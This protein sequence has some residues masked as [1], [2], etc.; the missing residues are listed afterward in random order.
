MEDAEAVADIYLASRQVLAPYAPLA[1]TDG[2]VRQWI[3]DHLIP[4]GRVTVASIDDHIVA[5]LAVSVDEAGKWVDQLYV[6]PNAVNSGI[7][8]QLLQNAQATLGPP[9]RLY[10]FQDNVGARRFYE[11]HGFKPIRYSDG[12]E[13]EEHCPDVLYEWRGE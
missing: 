12:A 5:M 4:K 11:R 1:H 10:A 7:G 8:T 9:I 13:N 6:H 3:R 2:A